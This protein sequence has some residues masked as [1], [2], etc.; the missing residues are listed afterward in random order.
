VRADEH[1]QRHVE[2]RDEDAVGHDACLV[3][4]LAEAIDALDQWMVEYGCSNNKAIL[5]ATLERSLGG[6]ES[7]ESLGTAGNLISRPDRASRSQAHQQQESVDSGGYIA[8]DAKR[9]ADFIAASDH[10]G[11]PVAHEVFVVP[12]NGR[13][14]GNG[15]LDGAPNGPAA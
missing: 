11:S 5:T 9:I 2:R 1:R 10:R 3:E 6:A 8:S 14:T 7:S 12:C 13:C 4:Q 15:S